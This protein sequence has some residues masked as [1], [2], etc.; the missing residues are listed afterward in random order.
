M[1]IKTKLYIIMAVLAAVMVGE[2]ILIMNLLTIPMQKQDIIDKARRNAYILQQISPIISRDEEQKL[3]VDM[4]K[5]DPQLSYLLILD[6]NG[7][8]LVH[9]EPQR[10]GKVFNDYGTLSCARHGESLQQIYIRDKE[11]PDSPHQGEKVVDIL[12]PNYDGEGRHIGAINAGVSLNYL[13]QVAQSHYEMLFVGATVL[14]IIFYIAAR[15]LYKDIISPLR[16]TVYAIRRVKEGNYS[17][18]IEERNDELGLLAREFN[19]MA[20]RISELMADLRQA[21]EELEN[22]VKQRTIELAAEKERLAVT[23][24]SI[25][26]GVIS[27]DLDGVIILSNHAVAKIFDIDAA[28]LPGK[29]LKEVLQISPPE[30]GVEAMLKGNAVVEVRNHGLVTDEGNERLIDAVGSPIRDE[31]GKY[32]GMV[33]VLHDITE[34]QRFEEELIKASKLESLGI[35]ASGLAH[36]FNNLLTVIAGNMSLARMVDEG[37]KNNTTTEF[38]EEA[39]KATLQASGLAQQL[40]SFSRGGEPKI[41]TVATSKLL[42]NSVNFALSGS[43]VSC[44]FII[45]DKLWN[46]EIDEGQI[47]QVL[48]NLVINAIQAMPDGG[49]IRI[50]A[51]NLNIVEPDKTLPLSPGKYVLL[52]I[53]DQG[54]GIPEKYRSRIF[55]PY[56]TTKEAGSGLGLATSDSI[57]RKH[58]GYLTFDSCINVGTT[59]FIY[60][61]VSECEREDQNALAY[62]PV[63]GQGRIL[64]MD[65]D[66][67]VRTVVTEML[68]SLGYEAKSA[69]N[70]KQAIEIY[71]TALQEGRKFAAVIMDLTT[72][73]KLGGSE[74]VQSILSLDPGAMIIL[75]SASSTEELSLNYRD[76]GFTS[77]IA[78]PYGITELSG[79]LHNIPLQQI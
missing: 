23:L 66:E 17:D 67:T 47:S 25:G 52:S 42:R 12:I 57:I 10:I 39:E 26:E 61:P 71:Q 16:K 50:S 35:L 58:G 45:P 20:S 6:C 40:L 76:M 14:I 28:D 70:V 38:L 65:N 24:S 21:H 22:R 78:K 73:N 19:S 74:A 27:T 63:K 3:V 77:F 54:K 36:D 18:S 75:S 30:G 7:K 32:E 41:K 44:E 60:L 62:P 8:A 79:M 34:K 56:F 33:W 2:I 9:S 49:I 11:L 48:N 51:R 69:E 37:S 5:R 29:N 68:I 46:V 1:K 55:E 13:D 59:F 72:R 31:S 43:N 15:K 4:V 53:A 64:V